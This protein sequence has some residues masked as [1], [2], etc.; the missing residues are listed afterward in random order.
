[1]NTG[2]I[3][4]TGEQ[5]TSPWGYF[6][7]YNVN[8]YGGLLIMGQ[9]DALVAWDWET[10]KIAWKYEYDAPFPYESPYTGSNGQG[11]FSWHTASY[12]ADG[13]IYIYNGEHT[14]TQ[15]ATRGW[16][17]HCINVT[18]GEPIWNI[19]G[20]Q[21]GMGDASRVFQGAIADGYLATSDGY[22]G[23]M[24]VFGKGKSAT[25][26]TAPDVSVPLGTALMLKGT[27]L[28][29]SPAQPGTP[30]VSKDSMTTQMEYL[31]MQMPIGGIYGNATI[32]GVPVSLD[33]F[34]P[35]GNYIHI[36]DVTTDGY[37]GTFGYAWTPE[38][39][40]EYTITA[41]FMGDDSYGSSLATTYANVGPAPEEPPTPIE[42]AVQ[43]DIDRAVD[44]LTPMF[45]GI[46]VAVA[47]AIVIG[48]VNL[49]ALRKRA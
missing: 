29:Q 24:Y 47:I 25:T 37:S 48:V 23:Y 2:D 46:I 34:D 43:E 11:V 26:V 30:C 5:T 36:A 42:P 38:I 39:E 4:W 12:I 49:W 14:A 20:S 33:A 16:K 28:D 3:L 35:N 31:H 8:S 7:T 19:M 9:F 10:G 13:K 15:P 6:G 44:S 21:S 45:L 40:G 32:M 18:T 22:T 41:T 1:V 27:V 17:L